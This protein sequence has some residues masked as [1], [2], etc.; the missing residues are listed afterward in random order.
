[1]YGAANVL[2]CLLVTPQLALSC[3]VHSRF[4]SESE[5]VSG[6]QFGDAQVSSRAALKTDVRGNAKSS[7]CSRLA[8]ARQN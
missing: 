6:P 4:C 1:M 8:G 7:Q 5:A 3:D 2:M